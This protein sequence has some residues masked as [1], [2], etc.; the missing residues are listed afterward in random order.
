MTCASPFFP[1]SEVT[2]RVCPP[3][4]PNDYMYNKFKHVSD[5]KWEIYAQCAQDLFMKSMKLD[6]ADQPN[7]FKID[8]LKFLT[9]RTNEITVNDRT[10][11]WPPTKQ[12]IVVT[13]SDTTTSQNC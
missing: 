13:D 2:L 12:P 4:E 6:F 3:F 10:W 1:M 7:R 11:F 9:G 5:E 8:Y